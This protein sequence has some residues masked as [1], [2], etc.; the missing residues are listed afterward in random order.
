MAEGARTTL[1]VVN[2]P[3]GL[4][5]ADAI[6]R[7]LPRT[8]NEFILI[9]ADDVMLP[10]RTIVTLE[11]VLSSDETIGAV[12]PVC[13]YARNHSR[14]WWAGSTTSLL[15]GFT[16]TFG[17]NARIPK[18]RVFETGTFTTVALVRRKAFEEPT[19]R[20]LVYADSNQFPM[21]YEESDFSFRI[22]SLGW[23]ILVTKDA[24]AYHDVPL[25]EENGYL[26]LWNVHTKQRAYFT[27]RNRIIFQ[28]KYSDAPQF[29]L[30]ALFF[31]QILLAQ[32]FRVIL[33]KSRAPLK[34][35]LG[36]LKACW[37]GLRDGL[38]SRP[39]ELY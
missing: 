18:S 5:A 19:S 8:S 38:Q 32:Y 21:H 4:F 16:K 22:R 27:C 28:K 23:R 20:R 12:A 13:F 35:K 11:R 29:V 2:L 30:F 14:I 25:P 31:N 7:T 24:S 6:N 17:V 37:Q 10:E 1:E 33:V 26:R 3:S 36:I 9:C 39:A 15:T 34:F